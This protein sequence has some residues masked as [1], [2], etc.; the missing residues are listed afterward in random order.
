M[1]GVTG[2]CR[3]RQNPRDFSMSGHHPCSPSGST[4]N[5]FIMV[6]HNYRQIARSIRIGKLWRPP[7]CFPHRPENGCDVFAALNF[8]SDSAN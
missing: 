1:D 7:P 2:L 6:R 5:V 4:P 3:V 8:G